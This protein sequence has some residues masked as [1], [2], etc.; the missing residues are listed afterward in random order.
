MTR[1]VVAVLLCGLGL[2]TSAGLHAQ[3]TPARAL[4]RAEVEA[5]LATAA[6]SSPGMAVAR[7]HNSDAYRVNVV[8][9]TAPQG[10]IAHDVG[11]EVHYVI[12]GTATLVT[13]GTIVRAAGAG[14][15]MATIRDGVSREVQAGDIV[16][17]PEGTPHWYSRLGAPLTYLEVRFDVKER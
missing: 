4:T 15:G 8:R 9:R 10:A 1:P 7:M 16:L 11:T 14:A 2:A 6:A 12:E 3:S 17:L 13:G 5:L